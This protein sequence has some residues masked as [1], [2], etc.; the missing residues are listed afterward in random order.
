MLMKACRL[1]YPRTAHRPHFYVNLKAGPAQ[2]RHLGGAFWELS[3]RYSSLDLEK[4]YYIEQTAYK[5]HHLGR[6]STASLFVET[7]KKTLDI[8]RLSLRLRVWSIFKKTP[9]DK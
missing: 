2:T 7:R 1:K 8:T 9:K 5:E 4:N 6:D 3:V